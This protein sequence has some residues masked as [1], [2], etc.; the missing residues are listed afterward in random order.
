M[1]VSPTCGMR[2]APTTKSRLMLPTT[3]MGFCM[4]TRSD[5]FT[6]TTSPSL[7]HHGRDCDRSQPQQEKN[8][9]GGEQFARG[10]RSTGKLLPDEHAPDRRD[11]RRTLAD[12]V[13]DCRAD[14]LRVRGDKIKH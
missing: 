3:T 4:T 12:G 7:L 13:G 5:C 1:I 11:H 8:E 14:D 6:V 9:H 10:R 2:S